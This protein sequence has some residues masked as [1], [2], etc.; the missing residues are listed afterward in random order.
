MK[1]F[2][3]T[4]LAFVYLTSTVGATLRLDCCL[5]NLVA[6][7]F[8]ANE[9]SGIWSTENKDCKDEHN[10]AKQ[11]HEQKHNDTHFRVAKSCPATLASDFPAYSFHA[12]ATITEAY[13]INNAPPQ[14]AAIPLFILNCVHRI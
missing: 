8:S 14:Q 12:I 5:E 11:G 13:P 10:Q 3:V 4:I 7:G 1:Q 2:L 6:T 9:H